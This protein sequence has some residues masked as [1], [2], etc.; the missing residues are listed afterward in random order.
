MIPYF[1]IN[2][3]LVGPLAVQVW[4][5]FVI[6]G[7]VAALI[8]VLRL[9][10]KYILSDD[11]VLDMSIWGLIGGMFGARAF[12]I[13][14]YNPSY[15][16]LRPFDILKFWEGGASSLGGFFG[17][18]AA[19]YVF[20]KIRGFSWQEFKPYLDVGAVSLWLGWGIGRIGCFIIH[21][22][23]GRLSNFFL[24]VNFSNGDRHDLGLYE[25]LV[26]FSLFFIFIFL[27]KRL[28]KKKWGLV[29]GMSFATYAFA[30][31]WL[32]FLRADDLYASD[33]RYFYFTPAQWG[34]AAIFLT[35]TFLMIW[36]KVR[37]QIN[38][39]LQITDYK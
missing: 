10:K 8:C 18:A 19:V 4:G 25:S 9:A 13:I 23:P 20:Y 38:S 6:F 34:M 14:F 17:A 15:Y 27:F 32:D 31:F 7:V 24:A 39:K 29:A 26:A 3:F 35:L 22:H 37:K 21:D 33:P 30:R 16:I 2:S 28:A 5:L 36:N 11:V 1:Q 12:H